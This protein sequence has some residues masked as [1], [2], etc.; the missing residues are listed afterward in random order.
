VA[1]L[2]VLADE[3]ASWRPKRFGYELWECKVQFEFPVVKLLDYR[4]R[5]AELEASRNP[6][7]TVVMAHLKAQETRRNGEERKRWKLS[8]TRRLHEQ[9]YNR[10]D[11][12]HLYRFIDWLMALPRELETGFWQEMQQYEEEKRMPYITSV[13]RIGIEKGL[14]QGILKNAREVVLDD[15]EV[16]FARVPPALAE[17][18]QGLDDPTF[19]RTLHRRAITVGSLAEFEQ[20][21]G[22]PA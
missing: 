1:S 15:L 4:A 5:W 19:L 21:L 17:R 11:I 20:V 6:F 10:E 2:V 3:R 13:E 16:R 22:E 14:Q 8:L 18:I 12:L 9:G 7:A